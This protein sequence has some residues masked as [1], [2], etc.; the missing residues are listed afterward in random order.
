M[1]LSGR[2]AD[3][4]GDDESAFIHE[5]I[6]SEINAMIEIMNLPA[7]KLQHA[8]QDAIMNK[9]MELSDDKEAWQ[10]PAAQ[11]VWLENV[12]I[13]ISDDDDMIEK[14]MNLTRENFDSMMKTRELV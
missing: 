1:K 8:N 2:R 14:V 13:K 10:T 11:K 9:L 4:F 6:A 5:R 3:V 7:E 12:I